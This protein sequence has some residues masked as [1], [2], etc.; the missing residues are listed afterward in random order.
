[1]SSTGLHVTCDWPRSW[2]LVDSAHQRH[3][4]LSWRRPG[5]ASLPF[6]NPGRWFQVSTLN[7]SKHRTVSDQALAWNAATMVHMTLSHHWSIQHS[8]GVSALGLNDV[9]FEWFWVSNLW[10]SNWNRR[11]RTSPSERRERTS[12][13]MPHSTYL[14]VWSKMHGWCWLVS[15]G[16]SAQHDFFLTS[17]LNTSTFSHLHIFLSSHPHI[18]TSSHLHILTFWHLLIFTSS[19]L[20]IT[21]SHH[22]FTSHLDIFSFSHLLIFTSCHLH[23]T[24]S[25]LHIFSSSHLH[26]LTSSHLLKFTSSHLHI[27]WYSHLHILTSSHSLLPSSSSHLHI[28]T[29]SLALLLSCPLAL[30]LSCSQCQRDGTKRNPFARNEVRSPK[31]EV[32]LRFHGSDRN[33]FARNE[34]RSPKIA[35]CK[36]A[37]EP[38]RTKWGS[39]AKNCGKI[40]GPDNPTS[41]LLQI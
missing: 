32:K 5:L 22:I 7:I 3:V 39:I 1:M 23:I 38:F 40:K 25:H 20:D 15:L 6:C 16:V 41:Q 2:N 11:A 9:L 18:F 37:G 8:I 10:C 28:F 21:S 24:S 29:F 12:L 19:H 26:I 17:S 34:V 36:S 13:L 14:L 35:I 30:L 33:L 31:T 4:A 27:F